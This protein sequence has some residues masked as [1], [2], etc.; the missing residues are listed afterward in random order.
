MSY[1]IDSHLEGKPPEIGAIYDRFTKLVSALPN[2]EITAMRAYIQIR[3]TF[4]YASV[5]PRI[6]YL[7]LHI[8]TGR[9]IESKRIVKSEQISRHRFKLSLHLT[10]P[11]ELNDELFGWLKEAYELQA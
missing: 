3:H 4:R 7:L 5:T 8:H 2:T 6:K 10:S 1:S 11:S 9:N